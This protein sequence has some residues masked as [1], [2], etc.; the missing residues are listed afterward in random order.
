MLSFM[1][2]TDNGDIKTGGPL[3]TVYIVI[4]TIIYALK[5]EGLT[6]KL[7]ITAR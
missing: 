6:R 3:L 1:F 2:C 7:P 5:I 4:G